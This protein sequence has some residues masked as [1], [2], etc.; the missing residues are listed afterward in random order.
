MSAGSSRGTVL[1]VE[2]DNDIR[3]AIAE[4]LEDGEYRALRAANGEIALEK[5]RGEASPPCLILLDMMMPV[6]DG[7]EFRA[8][9]QEDESLRKIPVIVLS[10]HADAART[11][12]QMQVAGYLKKPL[13]LPELLRTVEH[14][15]KRE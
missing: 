3:E 14:Y 2:D 12:C 10:A 9:Q 13:D 15:C 11:A 6:M 4:I 8:R 1:V 7:R 5:L